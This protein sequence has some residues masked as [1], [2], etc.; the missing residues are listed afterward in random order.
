MLKN[1]QL[2]FFNY[3][4]VEGSIIQGATVPINFDASCDHVKQH[5]MKPSS[6][7][8]FPPPFSQVSDTRKSLATNP[9]IFA[10][11]WC[12]TKKKTSNDS[13]WSALY[14]NSPK[15]CFL[16]AWKKSHGDDVVMSTHQMNF[17][18]RS[19]S[20]WRKAAKCYFV[21][22]LSS[23]GLFQKSHLVT[24][25][26]SQPFLRCVKILHG[27][28]SHTKSQTHKANLVKSYPRSSPSRLQKQVL[29]KLQQK[30]LG[31]LMIPASQ[32]TIP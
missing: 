24:G 32:Q 28:T 31:N 27:C 19:T 26:F 15:L 22:V 4:L 16:F 7:M 8:N 12:Y 18:R 5:G 17:S 6:R 14:R 25:F 9:D 20:L 23:C 3:I 30:L 11:H 10:A 1:S 29:R 13:T 2:G 21:L